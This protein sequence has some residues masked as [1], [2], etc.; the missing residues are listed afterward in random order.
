MSDHSPITNTTA[1]ALDQA[2]AMLLLAASMGPGGSGRAIEEQERRGQAELLH[3]DRMPTNLKP[4]KEAFEEVGF[5]FGEP[6]VGDPLFAPATLPDGWT[7]Q[8]SDHDMWTYIVD[9]LGRRRVSVFYKA[10]FYDRSAHA[11]LLPVY[12]YLVAC[13]HDGQEPI[14]D[15]TWATPEALAAAARVGLE[16]QEKNLK[17]ALHDHDAEDAQECAT[18]RDRY[19]DVL[20]RYSAGEEASGAAE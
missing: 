11:S 19:A 3:S 17:A 14:A 2:E 8:G 18:Y 5:T 13:V 16:Q 1:R 20:A 12:G 4:T 6:D 15:G 9:E 7:R 10:A